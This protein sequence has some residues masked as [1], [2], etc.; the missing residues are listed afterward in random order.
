MK[1]CRI[2]GESVHLS[3]H[4]SDCPSL[5][6]RGEVVRTYGHTD[7]WMDIRTNVQIPPVFYRTSSP[8]VPSGADAQKAIES[9]DVQD[10]ILVNDYTDLLVL[11]IYHSKNST[12]KLKTKNE[13]KTTNFGYQQSEKGHG[14]VQLQAYCFSMPFSVAIQLLGRLGLEKVQS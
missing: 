8:L 1:S 13:C 4:P 14:H 3:V 6:G 2:Q 12:N 9:S 5:K 11:A 7:V 10:T